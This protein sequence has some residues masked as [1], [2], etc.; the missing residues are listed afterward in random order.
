MK[1]ELNNG[2]QPPE[3]KSDNGYEKIEEM[4][5]F[6]KKNYLPEHLFDLYNH[7]REV[8][9]AF[10]T[11]VARYM[12]GEITEEEPDKNISDNDLFELFCKQK[13]G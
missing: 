10:K 4:L 3:P 1:G 6:V 8:A 11:F 12:N 5:A 9:I 13:E 7:D 2:L